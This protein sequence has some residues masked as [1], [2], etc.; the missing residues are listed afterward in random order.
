MSSRGFPIVSPYRSRVLDVMA[1]R[2]APMSSGGTKRVVMP[3]R[4]RVMA[5]W[6]W[7]PP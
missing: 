5:S 2:H 6:L 3:K 7:L 4:P 1:S